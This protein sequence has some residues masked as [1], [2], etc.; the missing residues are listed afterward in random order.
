LLLERDPLEP[1]DARLLGRRVQAVD[2]YDWLFADGPP[3]GFGTMG[4]DVPGLPS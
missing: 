4:E 3:D 1:D 2:R